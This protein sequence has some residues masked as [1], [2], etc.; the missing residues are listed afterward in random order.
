MSPHA[1][2]RVGRVALLVVLV[3]ATVLL[4]FVAGFRS[5]G[6]DS[7]PPGGTDDDVVGTVID[8]GGQLREDELY[9][10][11]APPPRPSSPAEPAPA[12]SPR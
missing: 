8:P 2:T 6:G 12:S 3:G 4:S 9:A 10:E 11:L 1:L 7:T 5:A